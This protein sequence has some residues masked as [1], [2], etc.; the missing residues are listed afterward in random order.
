LKVAVLTSSRADYS[1][2]YPLLIKLKQDGYF[3]LNIIAYG[4]HLSKKHGYTI[5]AILNDGFEVDY[6]VDTNPSSDKPFSISKAMGMVIRKF[7][8][9]WKNGCILNVVL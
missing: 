4:T 1:L 6:Y 8:G 5:D 9:I 2:L 7:S 3:I